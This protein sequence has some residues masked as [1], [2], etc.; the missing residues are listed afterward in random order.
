MSS[1]LRFALASFACVFFSGSLVDAQTPP[2]ED[3]VQQVPPPPPPTTQSVES[4][5]APGTAPGTAPAPGTAAA[6]GTAAAPGTGTAPGTA[7]APGAASAPAMEPSPLAPPGA[8]GATER[9]HDGFYLR[10][11]IGVGGLS[12]QR[13]G[14]L[15]IASG[16]GSG[17]G[18]A[19]YEGDSSIAGA[20]GAF[21]LSIGGTVARGLVICGTLFGQN[22]NEP[23]LVSEDDQFSDT[24]LGSNLSFGLIGPG[25]HWYPDPEGGFHFGGTVGLAYAFAEAPSGSRFEHIGGAGGGVSLAL[26]YDFW[27]ADQWSLGVMGRFTGAGLTGEAE[28]GGVTGKEEDTVSAF[29]LMFTAL[30]H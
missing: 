21:E 30:H 2:A 3:A 15:S 19:A 14:E 27:I 18:T 1:S 16:S 10:F 5:P 20:G 26:G 12:M 25:V 8:T 13:T 23:E 29:A 22:V 7:P 11:G 9:R 28:E 24:E 6:S 4:A 17:S